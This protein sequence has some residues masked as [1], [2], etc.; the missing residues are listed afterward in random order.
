MASSK[1]CEKVRCRLV[2]NKSDKQVYKG[3]V[4]GPI[5]E[6][7]FAKIGSSPAHEDFR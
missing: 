4:I 6:P 1:F 7:F 5:L 3:S 2:V